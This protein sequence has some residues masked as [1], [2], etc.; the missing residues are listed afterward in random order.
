MKIATWNITMLQNN[1]RIDIFTDEF[2]NFKL[3]LSG[4]SET[5]VPGVGNMK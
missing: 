2:R 3:D 1:N 5:H 4:D